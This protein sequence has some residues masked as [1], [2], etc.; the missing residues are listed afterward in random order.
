MPRKTVDAVVSK[1]TKRISVWNIDS[2]KEFVK[3]EIN[4]LLDELERKMKQFVCLIPHSQRMSIESLCPKCPKKK[5]CNYIDVK[6]I[7]KELREEK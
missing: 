6:Q 5:E 3:Q 7:I 2:D 4:G 1:I